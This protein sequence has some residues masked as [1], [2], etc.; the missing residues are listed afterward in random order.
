[1][2][3][4]AAKLGLASSLLIAAAGGCGDTTSTTP[5][6]MTAAFVPHNFDDINTHILQPSCAAFS[7]CHSAEGAR[8]ANMLDL[9]TDP[10][11]ALVGVRAV[12]PQ[13]MGE[14]KLRVKPCD[15]ANSF[16]TI[17][18]TLPLTDNDPNVGYGEYMPQGS[19]HLDDVSIQAIRDWIDRGALK[20]E[21]ATVTGKTCTNSNDMVVATD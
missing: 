17:K 11:T 19:G 12:N 16:L 9:K 5:A 7:V 20:N 6:D 14:G 4:I 15:S 3:K 2:W 8:D 1:M 21:P 18:L 10:Y 13:A